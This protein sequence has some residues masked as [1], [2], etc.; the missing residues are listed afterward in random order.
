MGEFSI[1]MSMAVGRGN[2]VLH[3]PVHEQH[4]VGRDPVERG[5]QRIER[6]G[7]QEQR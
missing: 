7:H 2:G 1:G 6:V 3:H 5:Q 4:R